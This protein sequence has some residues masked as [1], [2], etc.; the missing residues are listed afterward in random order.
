[1]YRDDR[2]LRWR[3]LMCENEISHTIISTVIHFYCILIIKVS[4]SDSKCK[5]FGKSMKVTGTFRC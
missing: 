3:L 1:M 2:E 4:E 5:R